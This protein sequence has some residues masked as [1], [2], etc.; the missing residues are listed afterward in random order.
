[1]HK[2]LIYI[3][4]ILLI[5]VVASGIIS[6]NIGRGVARLQ[7]QEMQNRLDSLLAKQR[8]AIV[9]KRVSLQMEDIAYQQKEI[10]D[11]QRERAEQQ[12]ILALKNAARADWVL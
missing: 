4:T 2:H 8:D 1:M 5:A 6:Y 3:I 10:S 11:K 12:S 9:T 7:L